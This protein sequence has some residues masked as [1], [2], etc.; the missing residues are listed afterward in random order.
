MPKAFDPAQ[1]PDAPPLPTPATTRFPPIFCRNPG[2][3]LIWPQPWRISKAAILICLSVLCAPVFALP[4]AYYGM[5][6]HL[7][8]YDGTVTPAHSR[9]KQLV[10][11]PAGMSAVR[12]DF[13]A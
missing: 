12:E 2:R 6:R 3:C 5:G 11:I 10:I 1:C 8:T 9:S 4:G 13:I 7:Q